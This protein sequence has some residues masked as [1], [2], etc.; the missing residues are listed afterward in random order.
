ML[1]TLSFMT[2]TFSK[3]EHVL[4]V[5]VGGS[6]PD[7]NNDA[8]H[9]RRGDVVISK[10][11]YDAGPLYVSLTEMDG[12]VEAGNVFFGTQ[13]WEARD[14]E[15]MQVV[16]DFSKRYS[17]QS[18]INSSVNQN[19]QTVLGEADGQDQKF[20]RPPADEDR[21]YKMNENCAWVEVDHP[22][23]AANSPRLTHPDRPVLH[24]GSIGTGYDQL[25]SGSI[26]FRK[27]FAMFNEIYAL[28]VG[29]QAVMES[30][31]GNRKDS[32]LIIRGIADYMDGMGGTE[33]QPYASLTAAAAMKTLLMRL[34]AARIY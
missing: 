5:G 28:D 6:V 11:E 3:I 1:F 30:I 7:Y 29:Y 8:R 16:V 14:R 13:T 22:D 32:F 18:M 31:Y 27:E 12:D 15:T 4:L 17:P 33:W 23:L 25:V 24:F 9:V 20:T 26:D 2:G 21:L 10:P 34:P 19:I